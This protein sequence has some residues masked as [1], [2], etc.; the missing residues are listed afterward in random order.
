LLTE[1]RRLFLRHLDL[2]LGFWA[3]FPRSRCGENGGQNIAF[4]S[5][6]KTTKAE[7]DVALIR[8]RPRDLTFRKMAPNKMPRTN[9]RR[10]FGHLSAALNKA[11]KAILAA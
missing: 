4:A 2:T 6:P 1:F 7:R 9:R 8:R 11:S 10:A 3:S 5:V